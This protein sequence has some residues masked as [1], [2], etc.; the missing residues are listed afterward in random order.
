MAWILYK[1]RNAQR[2]ILDEACHKCRGGTLPRP[3]TLAKYQAVFGKV[4]SGKVATRA[5]VWHSNSLS[6]KCLCNMSCIGSLDDNCNL[7]R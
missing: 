5:Y 2:L 6:N 1:M 7:A 3:I 4:A